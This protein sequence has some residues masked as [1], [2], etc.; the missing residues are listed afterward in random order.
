MSRSS[1]T[2]M[3]PSRDYQH[4]EQSEFPPKW[5][6]WQIN[7]HGSQQSLD[8]L[9]KYLTEVVVDIVSVSDPAWILRRG[10]APPGYVSV[11]PQIQREE[12]VLALLLIKSH[13]EFKIV[14]SSNAR[15]AGAVFHSGQKDWFFLSVYIQPNTGRGFEALSSILLKK[16][17]VSLNK[18]EWIVAGDFN[19]RHPHWGPEDEPETNKAEAILDLCDDYQ[20]TILNRFPC[21]P[22]FSSSQGQSWIDLTFCSSGLADKITWS[23]RQDLTSLSDHR[24][25]ETKLWHNAT[26]PREKSRP[27]WRKADWPAISEALDEAMAGFPCSSMW[28]TLNTKEDLETQTAALTTLMQEA[29]RPYVP[30]SGARKPRKH[31]W[32]DELSGYHRA[33]KRALRRRENHKRRYGGVPDL[34]EE[35]VTAAKAKLKSEIKKAKQAAWRNFLESNSETQSDLWQTFKRVSNAQTRPALDF[36]VDQNGTLLEDPSDIATTLQDKFFP[37]SNARLQDGEDRV[38]G[39]DSEDIVPLPAVSELE[40]QKAFCSGRPLAA[41]G[42]DGIPTAMLR[43]NMIHLGPHL[44][45]MATACLRL[46]LCPSKWKHSQV[47]ALHK[48]VNPSNEVSKLRPISLL[49]SMAKGMEKLVANRLKFWAESSNVLDENQFGFRPNRST[50]DA[51]MKVTDWIEE[52]TQKGLVVYGVTLDLKAAFDSISRPYLVDSLNRM[53]APTYLRRWCQ[54]FLKQRTAALQIDGQSYPSE[55]TA[56]VPQGSPLSP[57]LFILGV[58]AALQ[59]PKE[60]G[61][62]IQA[63]ADDILLLCRADTEEAAQIK[64]QKALDDLVSWSQEAGMQFSETKCLAIRFHKTRRSSMLPL[65][66]GSTKLQQV[67]SCRYLGTI[68]DERL[69]W[70]PHLRHVQQ[71]T[72]DRL[73]LIKKLSAKTW[74]FAPE[75][76]W[77]LTTKA[78]E[79]ALYY[80]AEV[81]SRVQDSATHLLI[82]NRTIRQAGLLITGCLRT[83]SYEA[84]FALSGL[85]PAQ[86]EIRRRILYDHLRRDKGKTPEMLS[87][88]LFTEGTSLASHRRQITTRQW[89]RSLPNGLNI[90]LPD[91]WLCSFPPEQLAALEADEEDQDQRPTWILAIAETEQPC[92]SGTRTLV[93]WKLTG[94]EERSGRGVLVAPHQTVK[95][96]VLSAIREGLLSLSDLR[97]TENR[98]Q[99]LGIITR[100]VI[101]QKERTNPF[102]VTENMHHI[103]KWWISWRRAGNKVNWFTQNWAPGRSP[104]QAAKRTAEL[105]MSQD[106]TR[107]DHAIYT[108]LGWCKRHI[109]FTLN[110]LA[111][112][113]QATA[114]KGRAVLDLQPT[115]GKG[116]FPSRRLQRINAS[117]VNQFLAN[118][119]PSKAYLK[120][121]NLAEI[122]ATCECGKETKTEITCSTPAPDLMASEG[123]T[124]KNC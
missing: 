92:T 50:T 7:M 12:E 25:V 68:L 36:V 71:R 91:R 119:F 100:R 110:S 111:Q 15:L 47:V 10:W 35:A 16:Y 115:T 60:P 117:R 32:T 21:P 73:S 14:Y 53:E 80:G 90:R 26:L 87:D 23:V 81:L 57:L 67:K 109:S 104:Y 59:I 51:L 112:A 77:Q 98:P 37:S 107:L 62:H 20:M 113:Q 74:G 54:D 120:R 39:P 48:G 52:H 66:I 82:I 5:T 22:T 31:W 55:T 49:N 42:P 64:A 123:L 116:H 76:M 28:A 63:Y 17:D 40:A 114:D 89:H 102:N 2:D 93:I 58:N 9:S 84:V 124:S 95:E 24:I 88:F 27:N 45:E 83:T 38:T 86:M 3:A 13:L 61:V 4:S 94:P 106:R 69:S 118:H 18:Q 65:H 44:K 85:L 1:S 105:L 75:A 70:K 103:Q 19:S 79:P 97:Q 33:L 29:A 122:D 108:D 78:L 41:P 101:Y 8:M 56:G 30:R 121:F 96:V 34:L 11:R 43:R 46:H 99:S 72:R 6:H